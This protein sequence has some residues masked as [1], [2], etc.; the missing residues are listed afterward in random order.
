MSWR[1][2][3]TEQI[4]L[5]QRAYP[6]PGWASGRIADG[7][8]YHWVLVAP[9][10]AVLRVA[11]SEQAAAQMERGARLVQALDHVLPYRLPRPLAP[12]HWEGRIGAVAQEFIPGE[13]HPPGSGDPAMLAEVCRS[14][15]AV[16]VRP[17]R[18]LLAEPFAFQGPWTTGRVRALVDAVPVAIRGQI[19]AV[20]DG[21]HQMEADRQSGK[22]RTGL[23]H[24][25][26]AGHNVHWSDGRVAGI[27]D[28]DLASAWDVALNPAYLSLWHGIDLLPAIAADKAEA[29]RATVWLGDLVAEVLYSRLAAE[30]GAGFAHNLTTHAARIEQ[31]ARAADAL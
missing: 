28:W 1:E 8:E 24:A 29:N 25:D 31:A 5:A 22:I 11:R 6:G 15:A 3:T 17:L 26:L 21:V 20:L 23:V 18:P 16:D 9:D 4:A 10:E 14:L 19:T 13:A 2:P 12:I 7:G 27:L 30:D